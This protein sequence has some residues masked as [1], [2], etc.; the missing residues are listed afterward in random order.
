MCAGATVVVARPAR[1]ER[2]E[3]HEAVTAARGIGWAAGGGEEPPA[4]RPGEPAGR[5]DRDGDGQ[6]VLHRYQPIQVANW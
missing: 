1:F 5:G 2:V 6:G 3:R 4:E